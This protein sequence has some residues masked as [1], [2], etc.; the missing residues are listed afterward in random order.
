[1]QGTLLT[2]RYAPRSGARPGGG[3]ASNAG[4]MDWVRAIYDVWSRFQQRRFYRIRPGSALTSMPLGE[5]R[6]TMK[7]QHGGLGLVKLMELWK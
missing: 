3:A 4:L 7:R 2:V 1:M 6:A 5:A